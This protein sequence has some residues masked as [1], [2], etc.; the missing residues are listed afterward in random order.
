MIFAIH[1][2]DSAMGRHMSPHPE[3]PSHLPPH[4]IPLG[5]PRA[6][7]LGDRLHASK[8]HWSTVLH[9][10]IYLFH[11]Y[12]LKSS[13]PCLLP[14][15]PKVSSFTS[16]FLLLPCIRD[17]HYRLSKFHIYALIY[18]ICVSLSDLLQEIMLFN[19]QF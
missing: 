19:K 13:H 14:Q 17:H 16:L 15:S 6:Q 7:A 1:Q 10:I 5:H 8:L 3:A 9:T 11:C 12:S 18:S 2:H 4:P